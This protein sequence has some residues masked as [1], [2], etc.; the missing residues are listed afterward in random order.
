MAVASNRVEP[1]FS[2]DWS[3]ARDYWPTL[4][5]DMVGKPGLD[6][7]E[8]GCFEGRATLWMLENVLTD[9]SSMVTVVDTFKGNPEFRSMKINGDCLDRFRSNIRGY[10]DKVDIHVGESRSVLRVLPGQF[11]FVYIDGSHMAADVLSDAVMAWPLLKQGGILAFDD[12]EWPGNG[13]PVNSPR[14][15]IDAFLEVHEDQLKVLHQAY[16]VAVR[17]T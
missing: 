13:G 8:V 10:E 1:V 17:K 5:K 11:D 9:P 6:F 4:L 15:A 2:A 16:Q 7:L 3:G 14:I 12:Y